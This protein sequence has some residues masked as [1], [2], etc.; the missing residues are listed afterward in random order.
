M[1][2]VVVVWRTANIYHLAEHI[3]TLQLY[4]SVVYSASTQ[5]CW[6]HCCASINSTRVCAR[7]QYYR[8]RRSHETR[9]LQLVLQG[10]SQTQQLHQPRTVLLFHPT[11]NALLLLWWC[12]S[13][14]RCP[15]CFGFLH[16]THGDVLRKMTFARALRSSGVGVSVA[17]SLV[18]RRETASPVRRLTSRMK[19]GGV[20]C[21]TEIDT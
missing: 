3:P 16:H 2:C 10:R 21:H 11:S 14:I 7:Q 19:H 9:Y 8:L 5:V 18:C 1:V 15:I 20:Y 4:K 6:K 17:T 12:L 13:C